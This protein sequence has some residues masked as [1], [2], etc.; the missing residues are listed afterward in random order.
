[1]PSLLIYAL[2]WEGRKRQLEKAT[3]E[4]AEDKER[5]SSRFKCIFQV[6]KDETRN[7][8]GDTDASLT[9]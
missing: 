1:M 4:A 5:L 8:D 2:I 3:P 7:S 6:G 9:F